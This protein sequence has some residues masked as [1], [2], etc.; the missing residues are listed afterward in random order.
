MEIAE[1]LKD[2]EAKRQKLIDEINLLAEETQ[3][4]AQRRQLL[5]QEALRLDGEIRAY[6]SL[7]EKKEKE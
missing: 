4:I 2:A 5:L 1:L 7:S 6:K 3:A